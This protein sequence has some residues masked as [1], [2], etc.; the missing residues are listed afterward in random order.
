MKYADLPVA[1][2]PEA[3]EVLIF[4]HLDESPDWEHHPYIPVIR[5]D[6]LEVCEANFVSVDRSV[7]Y[8]RHRTIKDLVVESDAWWLNNEHTMVAVR[9]KWADRSGDVWW[10]KNSSMVW[11]Y[12][13]RCGEWAK[14]KVTHREI[15][16]LVESL[17]AFQDLDW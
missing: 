11:F 9:C 15:K 16:T 5:G 13:R 8:Y 2:L 1:Y 10:K 12:E 17:L 7:H 6:R 4:K 3:T 14:L